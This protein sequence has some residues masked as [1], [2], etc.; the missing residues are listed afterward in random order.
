M[1]LPG[2]L[3][4]EADCHWL[5]RGELLIIHNPSVF[6]ARTAI[7]DGEVPGPSNTLVRTLYYDALDCL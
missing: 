3:S 2:L 1:R 6:H 4:T 5:Q 7:V